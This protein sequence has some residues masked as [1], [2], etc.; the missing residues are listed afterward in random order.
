[1][2]NNNFL[3][4]I[5]VGS[6]IAGVTYLLSGENEKKNVFKKNRQWATCPTPDRF[7]DWT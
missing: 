6:T 3:K 2:A 4:G 1:M 7:E 5:V